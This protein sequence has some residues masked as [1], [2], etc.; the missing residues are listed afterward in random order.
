M[1]NITKNALILALN[2]KGE[3]N[4]DVTILTEDEGIVRA[5]LYGGA[6]SKLRSL[7]S[8]LNSGKVWL[9]RDESKKNCKISDFL[10][11]KCRLSIRESLVKSAQAEIM[12]EILIR[13][14][15]AGSPA[16][17]WILANAFLDGMDY[18]DDDESRR[19]F[20]RFLWRY[21]D[22][23]G[24]RPSIFECSRCAE[25][26]V[27]LRGK[28][29]SARVSLKREYDWFDWIEK[30][31]VCGNCVKNE[32]S[33]LSKVPSSVLEYL[34]NVSTLS[35]KEARAIPLTSEV[36]FDARTF[37][38]SLIENA[39]AFPLKSVRATEVFL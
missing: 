22:I 10:V 28:N 7:V 16:E 20:V 23:L 35:P 31:F 18:F 24:E 2:S 1:R 27:F 12:T 5:T 21:L 25:R 14:K 37:C 8:P 19:G 30:A 32:E 34:W 15:A 4:K 6:K 13:T 36:L 29:E 39:I 11:E 3:L 33:R 26:F 9:Y 38:L 17:S